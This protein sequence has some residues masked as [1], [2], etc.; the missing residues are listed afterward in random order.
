MKAA[1]V[2]RG[3]QIGPSY[4]LGTSSKF[5]CHTL[6]NTSQNNTECERYSEGVCVFW[7]SSH[8][9]DHFTS[10]EVRTFYL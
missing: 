10:G 3:L 4:P 1:G 6:Q 5:E 2:K 9:E 7:Y 8:S